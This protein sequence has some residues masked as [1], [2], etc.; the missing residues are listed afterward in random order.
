MLTAAA[1][2]PNCRQRTRRGEI[3]ACQ[4]GR[5]QQNA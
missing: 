3:H 4:M 2:D 1:I 5:Q